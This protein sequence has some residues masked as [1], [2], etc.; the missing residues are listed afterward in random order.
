MAVVSI[1]RIQ[2]RRGRRTDLPQ[3]ASGEFG[4]AVDSQELYIGNGAVSEGA[5]YVGNTKL[6]TEHDDLFQLANTYTYKVNSTIQTGDTANSPIERTLQERLDDIVSI[7]SFGATGDGT[8]QTAAIQ[9]ALDEL[10]LGPSTKNNEVSRVKLF[11]DPGVYEISQTIHIPPYATI[12]GAGEDKTIFR[13]S[14]DFSNEM[15]VTQNLEGTPGVPASRSTTTSLN[16]PRNI[17]VSGMTIQSNNQKSL[18]VDC[19]ADS[20]FEN[21]KFLG[22]FEL[23]NS[24]FSA[25]DIA[26]EIKA[27]SQAV[28]SSN[29]I[30]RNI[31]VKG[32][33]LGLVADDDVIN[34]TFEHCKFYELFEGV[35]LG[36]YTILGSP[37]QSYG[38]RHTKINNCTFDQI[39]RMAISVIT[40]TSNTSESNKFFSVGNNGGS[41][42]NAAW[43]VIKFDT[44]N[45][46]SIGD[47]FARTEEL[48]FDSRYSTAVYIPE[49]EGNS[50]TEIEFTKTIPINEVPVPTKLLGF[51]ADR[52]KTIEVEYVYKSETIVATRTGTLHITI[53]PAYNLSQ[54]TDDFDFIGGSALDTEKLE[55]SV[56]LVDNNS[57]SLLDT[58]DLN[59]LN[60][61]Q[62]DNAQLE[63]RVK[64]K[65]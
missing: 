62:N 38:P 23:I 34:N 44:A 2:I 37:G 3:L 18:I 10:F 21:I 7:R 30:F 15:F 59:V 12:V 28:T 8:D 40:G 26:I 25:S 33:N 31:S 50:I 55:F 49:V 4:W 64:I 29:N 48:G 46:Q 51:A 6:L 52:E 36:A 45:N 19:C 58:L 27:L 61:T 39:K 13:A 24:N 65:S 11:I 35:K 14:S 63:Y 60:L 5:P 17:L 1:S 54:I 56:A 32:K 47:W 9:R 41:P 16:Q 20:V 42:E 43:P 53:N 22:S 57:D